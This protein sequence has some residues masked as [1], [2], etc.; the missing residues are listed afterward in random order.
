MVPPV[1]AFDDPKLAQ[2]V[3]TA[4]SSVVPSEISIL[5]TF[6]ELEKRG[7]EKLYYSYDPHWN[8][9]GHTVVTEFLQQHIL[10]K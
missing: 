9:E 10:Q 3:V 7:G 5:D 8:A 1:E 6:P 2:Q 4:I